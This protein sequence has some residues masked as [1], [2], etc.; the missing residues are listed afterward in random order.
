MTVV[1]QFWDCLK[2]YVNL[3]NN[4]QTLKKPEY[5]DDLPCVFL[6]GVDNMDGY[7]GGWSLSCPR[8]TSFC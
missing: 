1:L 7:G 5:E 6:Y 2:N 3:E 4:I 8:I